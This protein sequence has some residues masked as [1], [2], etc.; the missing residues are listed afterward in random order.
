AG[1]K[2]KTVPPGGGTG[3]VLAFLRLRFSSNIR[4]GRAPA[5]TASRPPAPARRRAG[6]RVARPSSADPP[7]AGWRAG[8]PRTPPGS[9]AGWA[10]LAASVPR[11]GSGNDDWTRSVP[12][13]VD[14]RGRTADLCHKYYRITGD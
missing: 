12:C 3:P 9:V 8:P 5:A 1:A 14:G 7:G 4:A 10:G 2:K 6:K 11:E 13:S